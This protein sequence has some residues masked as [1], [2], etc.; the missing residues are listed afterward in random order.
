MHLFINVMY[1]LI[2]GEVETDNYTKN[3]VRY[4]LEGTMVNWMIKCDG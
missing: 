4:S 2:M 1:N 3:F